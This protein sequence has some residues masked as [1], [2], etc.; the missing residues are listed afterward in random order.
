MYLAKH[1]N[2]EVVGLCDVDYAHGK[3]DTWSKQFK[4]ATA[5]Q[6]YREMLAKLD[7]KIDAVSISTPD[8]TH[9]PATMDAMEE[10]STSTCKKP[11]TH[12]SRRLG[13]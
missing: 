7:D 9:Y 3:I 8:H 6:D 13:T 1:S 10:E 11:L 12:S 4:S 2:V 5:F